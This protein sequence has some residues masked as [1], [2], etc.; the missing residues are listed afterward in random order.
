MLCYGDIYT[1]L[2]SDGE[3][4]MRGSPSNLVWFGDSE[5]TTRERI[6]ERCESEELLVQIQLAN[7]VKECV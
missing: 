5:T 6:G 3:T 4:P 1:A 2:G 7:D